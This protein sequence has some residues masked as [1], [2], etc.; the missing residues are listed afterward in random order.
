MLKLIG[1]N[2]V[3]AFLIGIL[4]IIVI[5]S[6]VAFLSQAS[7]PA[8]AC[9]QFGYPDYR[10]YEGTIYCVRTMESGRQEIVPLRSLLK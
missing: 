4:L 3:E 7:N 10:T 6:V 1:E 5:V 9:Y 2:P 8:G